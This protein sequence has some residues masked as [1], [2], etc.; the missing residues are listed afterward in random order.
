MVSTGK[1]PS[2]QVS[3]NT[4]FKRM[5]VGSTHPDSDGKRA[6]VWV[7][8]VTFSRNDVLSEKIQFFDRE[9]G[10]GPYK[11]SDNPLDV[12]TLPPGVPTAKGEWRVI[13]KVRYKETYDIGPP[14]KQEKLKRR[15]ATKE[16]QGTK[17][18]ASRPPTQSQSEPKKVK[19]VEN[20]KTVEKTKKAKKNSNVKKEEEVE[21]G[22]LAAEDTQSVGSSPFGLDHSDDDDQTCNEDVVFDRYFDFH[23]PCKA[24][25]VRRVAGYLVSR[26]HLSKEPPTALLHTVR[27]FGQAFG[28]KDPTEA[29]W[30]PEYVE[31]RRLYR[32]DVAVAQKTRERDE[33][34]VG[35]FASALSIMRRITEGY[36]T[37]IAELR[38]QET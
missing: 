14:S 6:E 17:R 18:K 38:R 12:E 36:S 35:D 8:W 26:H 28:R 23:T 32:T 27:R 20:V 24:V 2:F 33:E 5:R 30:A 29:F 11:E 22:S 21:E 25:I 16:Q 10:G 1:I 9:V 19:K 7:S 37:F 15:D 3:K 13:A 31:F 4:L 34:S